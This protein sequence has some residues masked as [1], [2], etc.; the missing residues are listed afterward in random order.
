MVRKD[1]LNLQEVLNLFNN[2]VEINRNTVAPHSRSRLAAYGSP[3]APGF[4]EGHTAAR[5]SLHL[6]EVLLALQI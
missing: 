1:P 2:C 4:P 5:D 6:G 3:L